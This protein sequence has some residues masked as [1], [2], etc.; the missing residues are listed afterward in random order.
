MTAHAHA[1]S[2]RIIVVTNIE[3]NRNAYTFSYLPLTILSQ[4]LDYHPMTHFYFGC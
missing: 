1:R 3:R 4:L 2:K